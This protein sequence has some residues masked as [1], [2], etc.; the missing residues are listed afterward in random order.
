MHRIS[1]NPVMRMLKY[2]DVLVNIFGGIFVRGLRCSQSRCPS[3][4]LE[5]ADEVPV[6]VK[7]TVADI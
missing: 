5:N 3:E 1:T 2:S 7:L 4:T 6:G